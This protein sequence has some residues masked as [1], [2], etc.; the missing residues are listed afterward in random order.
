[1]M[2][3]RSGYDFCR[4]LKENPATRLIPEHW[5]QH[6]WDW[7]RWSGFCYPFNLT[8]LPAASC[9]AGFDSRGLPIGMQIVGRRFADLEVLQAA[10]AFEQ[11][12]PWAQHRPVP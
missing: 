9:P 8:G 4:A 6:P 3:G 11:A 12:R 2:P 1:M 7:L 10:R 5:E